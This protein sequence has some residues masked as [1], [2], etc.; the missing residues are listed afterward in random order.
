[1]RHR[2]LVGQRWSAAA[3]DSALE[4][5][6]LADWR[7]LL[8]RVSREPEDRAQLMK[9][10][11]DVAEAQ[12]R[13]PLEESEGGIDPAVHWLW[14]QYLRDARDPSRRRGGRAS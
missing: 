7:G 6:S 10:R 3:V 5:G 4:R 2:H 1:M 14:Q 13:R 9:V 8:E 12:V 11:L